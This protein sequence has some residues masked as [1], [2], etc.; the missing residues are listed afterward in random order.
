MGEYGM[1]VGLGQ[2]AYYVLI[3]PWNIKDEV[4]QQLAFIRE[5]GGQFVIPIPSLKV[6]Q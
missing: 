3:L 4:M 1:S 6:V 5:W 2:L